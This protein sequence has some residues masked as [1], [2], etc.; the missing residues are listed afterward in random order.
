MAL[1]TLAAFVLLSAL[2]QSTSP[3]DYSSCGN[4]SNLHS[5]LCVSAWCADFAFVV[6]KAVAGATN[7]RAAQKM[8]LYRAHIIFR[9]YLR[10]PP[11]M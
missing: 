9:P 1:A 5:F 2:L 3:S 4:I 11:S 7:M 6:G 8:T 10:S